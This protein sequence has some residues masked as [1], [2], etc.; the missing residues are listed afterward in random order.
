MLWTLLS[1][2]STLLS[3][4]KK[5]YLHKKTSKQRYSGMRVRQGAATIRKKRL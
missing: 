1:R 2:R 4:K 3:R 5:S